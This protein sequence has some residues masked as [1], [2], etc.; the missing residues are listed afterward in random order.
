MLED[1]S[2]ACDESKD[3]DYDHREGE[4]KVPEEPFLRTNPT[5]CKLVKMKPPPENK[6]KESVRVY[7]WVPY[8]L[9]QQV[10]SKLV[11]AC[12]TG[13]LHNKEAIIEL[14]LSEDRS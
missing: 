5:H 9:S 7:K 14:L 8:A 12:K 13:K 4:T 1:A 2:T 3:S 10:L 6:N 11:V